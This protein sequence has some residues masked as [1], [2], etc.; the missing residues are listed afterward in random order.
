MFH[1]QFRTV[2]IG[3]CLPSSCS[4]DDLLVMTEFGTKP[5]DTRSY[6]VTGIRI[7]GGNGY[8]LWKDS[9]FITML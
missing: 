6:A 2:H 7:P 1:L 8:K 9:T 3:A 5:M 4:A